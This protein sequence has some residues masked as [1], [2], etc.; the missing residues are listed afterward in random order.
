MYKELWSAITQ[1][2]EWRGEF[3]TRKKNG[4]IFWAAATITPITNAKGAITHFLAIKEDITER[5][6]LESQLRQA[7]KL[8]G[9]GQLAAGI[10]PTKSTRPR[11]L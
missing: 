9:I 7:Q 2:R 10:A 4:E 8:A 5:C 11:S 1:G 3:C 6:V